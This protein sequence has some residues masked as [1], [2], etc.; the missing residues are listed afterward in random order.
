M[1]ITAM[2][3]RLITVYRRTAFI[4]DSVA[5]SA[6]PSSIAP[7]RQPAHN[8]QVQ[9][10][11][12]GTGAGTV[13][14]NGT[15]AT[16]ADSEVLSFAAGG[17]RITAKAFDAGSL[18]T[19][20]YSAGFSAADEIEA[21]SMGVNGHPHNVAFVLVSSWPARFDRARPKWPAPVSGS[22]ELERTRVYVDYTTVWSPREGDVFV[23]ERTSEEFLVTGHP[24]LFDGAST[25]PHHW[26]FEVERR[27]QSTTT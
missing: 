12:T 26:E 13:T 4:L 23:D 16:V 6:V 15:V 7:D 22:A 10:R 5:L 11:V 3:G 9:V 2:A 21:K 17:I 24:E 8:G 1:S 19:L 20:D 14:V 27:K 18:T 25:V